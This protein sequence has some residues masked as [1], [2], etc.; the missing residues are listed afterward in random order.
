MEL[1]ISYLYLPL[2]W[3]QTVVS[4][5]MQIVCEGTVSVGKHSTRLDDPN[6][7]WEASQIL[8]AQNS[9]LFQFKR[10]R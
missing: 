3:K 6:I 8:A 9:M 4:L 7:P 5:Q 1:G 2:Y 10:Y